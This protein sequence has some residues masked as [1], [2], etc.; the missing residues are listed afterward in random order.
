MIGT[1]PPRRLCLM[2]LAVPTAVVRVG[3][4]PTD[5][6]GCCPRTYP[7]THPRTYPRANSTCK[8]GCEHASHRAANPRVSSGA[9]HRRHL[10]DVRSRQARLCATSSGLGQPRP[11]ATGNRAAAGRTAAGER[12]SG[13]PGRSRVRASERHSRTAR[14]CRR[15]VQHAL[16]ARDEVAVY[17]RECL[18]LRRRPTL[19]HAHGRRAR[20]DQPR[21]LSPRLYGV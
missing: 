9:F 16:S 3:I 5:R 17:G 15:V 2:R 11:G 18:H 13:Q 14:G 20:G 6:R 19:A 4:F 12:G 8:E 7:R 1:P 21:P 10:R